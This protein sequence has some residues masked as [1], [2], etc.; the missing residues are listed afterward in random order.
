MMLNQH[1]EALKD[2]RQSTQIDPQFYKGFVRTAK[3][4]LSLGEPKA[5]INQLERAAQLT[6][7][8]DQLK[9]DFEQAKKLLSYLEAS[10]K[11][12][13]CGDFRKVV[14]CMDR[15]I[16]ISPGCIKFITNKAECL[17]LL[18]RYE[19]AQSIAF[20]LLRKDNL[21]ADALYVRGLCL[22]YEDNVDKAFSHFQR[23]LQLAPDHIKAKTVYKKA[24]SL[25]AKKEEGN[26]AFKSG[27][28]DKAYEVYT[29]A[30]N[31]D[32]LNVFTNSKLYCNRATVC[33]KLGK[34]KNAIEDC[35][36]AISLDESYLKA[37]LRRAKC[38][39]DEEQ[40]EEAVVDYE[41]IFQM[42]KTR[43]NKQ[44]LQNAKLELKKSKRKDY[45]KI[46]GISKTSS[47]DEIRK[48][49][50][51]R[52]LRHHPDRHS[53]ADDETKKE[54]EKKFKEIGEAY[55]VLSDPKK[56]ERY[57]TGQDLDEGGFQSDFDPNTIFQAF[58]GGGGSRNGGFPFG[59]AGG[60]PGDSSFSFSFG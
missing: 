17:A 9:F 20:D 56:R 4:L 21:N 49:Y 14:Y 36:K 39:M 6:P 5:A 25:I 11:A 50:R 2:A 60:F 3:C 33:S 28:F 35:S 51:K 23:V 31:I 55:A 15:C 1:S 41:K 47:D 43:E 48:A 44:A 45:Y 54:E 27:E 52:A 34:N 58:F 57:D 26:T 22:Y 19:E 42:Q 7:N 10:D 32:P 18:K 46:L 30:L 40:Y 59:G 53:S 24:K 29:S 12:Y 8:N 16:D 13:E 37:Y 38:Y